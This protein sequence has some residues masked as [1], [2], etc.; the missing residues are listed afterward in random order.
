[1][2]KAYP[3]KALA[4][5]LGRNKRYIGGKSLMDKLDYR[6]LEAFQKDFPLTERPYEAI[7]DKLKIPCEQLLDRLQLLMA[8]GVIRRIGAS[9]DSRKFGYCS[10]LAAIS[11]EPDFIKQAAEVIGKFP[12]VTH[13]YL[14]TDRFNI[15]FTIIASDNERFESIL[16]QI[17]S[18]LLLESSQI[19][20]LPMKRLF[21]LNACFNIAL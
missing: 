5:E 19:L 15:W 6:I 7:S 13:S 10:T 11:V 9:L 18:A 1:L 17:Q 8:D 12:E 14:R 4:D 3:T 2:F 20:N 16:K 21:K